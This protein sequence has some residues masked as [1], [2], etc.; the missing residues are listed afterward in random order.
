MKYVL[1]A[2]VGIK[3]VMN[4]DARL[5]GPVSLDPTDGAGDPDL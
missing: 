5:P 4:E 3:W 2:A 1:D